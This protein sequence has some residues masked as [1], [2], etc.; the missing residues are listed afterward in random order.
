[1]PLS[2]KV[3][4]TLDVTETN[5]LTPGLATFQASIDSFME[6]VTGTGTG[7]ANMVYVADRS[8]AGG[9][10]DDID[11]A[12]VLTRPLG[13][14]FTAA[15]IVGILILNSPTSGVANTTNLTLGGGTNPVVGYLGGTT[16]T[17]GPIRPGG[18]R[19]LFETD[20]AGLCAVTSATGDILRISNGAG[21]VN[22]Y[23]IA[24]LA[25]DVA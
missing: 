10:N 5:P 8:V 16:P 13:G 25:R 14:V 12:G 15:E 19:A 24:V 23:R 2:A 3:R 9:A 17:I 11:L 7:Q 4:M 6:F 1:M 18:M 21:A 22:N 20:A